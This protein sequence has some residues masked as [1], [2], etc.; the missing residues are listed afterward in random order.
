[1]SPSSD[2]LDAATL[3]RLSARSPRYTSYPT[4]PAWSADVDPAALT[5]GMRRIH[6]PAS[7][8]VHV[9]FCAEQCSF[10]ACNQVVAGRRDAGDRYLDA[11]E[12]QLMGLPLP[13]D[14]LAVQRIHLGGGTPTWLD[15]RQLTRLLATL[16]RRFRREPGAELS[17]EVDPEITTDGQVEL[18]AG[19]GATRLSM[20]VQSFD[21]AVLE[22]V[23][24]PQRAERIGAIL[25]RA[26]ALGMTG[27]NIDLMYGLPRQDR[28]AFQAD[29]DR[30]IALAPDRLAI[31]G[32]AHVPW[33]KPHQKR[34]EPY[35]LQSADDRLELFLLAHDRLRAAGYVPIGFDHFARPDDALAKAAEAGR[36]HRNFMGYTTLPEV[37]LIGLG[38]SAITEL[39]G[40]FFQQESKLSR[41][42]RAVEEGPERGSVG[43][44]EKGILLTRDDRIRQDV[45]RRIM[46][47]LQVDWVEVAS[48]WGIDPEAYFAD[49][50]AR[51]APL[52]ALGIVRREPTR[53]FVPERG[54]LVVRNVAM[55]FDAWLQARKA[56]GPETSPRFSSSI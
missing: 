35:G 12:R 53:L 9:P 4:A 52:E 14:T 10:C 29:L 49:D 11:I 42:W 47:S 39:R 27:L 8:Y 25:R 26:R 41:W 45:I 50:L 54:R 36:L 2:R 6:A 43:P 13:A 20:G 40:A 31:F 17:A 37:E 30:T 33:L 55:A 24:R 18:L 51:L 5:A 7:V 19:L 28:R 48:R 3:L 44:I 38:M 22:A 21:P 46:C 16:D 23:G 15:D 32:Y 56:S 34:L 1:M